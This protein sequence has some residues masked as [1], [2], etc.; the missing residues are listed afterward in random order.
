MSA[1]NCKSRLGITQNE[2][3][4]SPALDTA[5]LPISEPF[6]V[7]CEPHF[8][9]KILSK[10][11]FREPLNRDNVSDIIIGLQNQLCYPFVTLLSLN[12]SRHPPNGFPHGTGFP[13]D[14][15]SRSSQAHQDNF[16]GIHTGLAVSRHLSSNGTGSD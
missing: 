3:K 7:S 9:R 13:S 2:V 8:D 6:L 14:S 15:L 16:S 10:T 1:C 11:E 12:G 4:T 5:Q